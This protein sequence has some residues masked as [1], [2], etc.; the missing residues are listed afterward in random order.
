MANAQTIQIGQLQINYLH[1]GAE[2]GKLGCFEMT[3]PSGAMVPPPHSHTN[4]DEIVYVLEGTLRYSFGGDVRDLNVGDSMF[5]PRGSVHG[6]S[7]PHDAIARV[8]IT[9]SPDIGAQYFR[10]I[11]EVVSAGGPP[12]RAKLMAVMSQYGLVPAGNQP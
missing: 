9:N 11:A 12:D 6:F 8:L 7:N 3:V 1:D 10:D 2:S 4:N 5:S